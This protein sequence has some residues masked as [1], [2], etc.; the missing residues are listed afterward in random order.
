MT[1]GAPVS[2][3]C[4]RYPR[5]APTRPGADVSQPRAGRRWRQ[6]RDWLAGAGKGMKAT[7]A[8]LPA[9][10][11]KRSGTPHHPRACAILSRRGGW[12][13]MT[14]AT[15]ARGM[16]GGTT[17]RPGCWEMRAG[18]SCA[19]GGGRRAP[20]APL[21]SSAQ[22]PGE[23]ASGLRNG[24]GGGNL[25]S[26]QGLP[27]PC[28]LRGPG[29]GRGVWVTPSH[30]AGKPPPH[31]DVVFP[32]WRPAPPP[33]GQVSVACPPLRHDGRCMTPDGSTAAATHCSGKVPRAPLRGAQK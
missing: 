32:R 5:V 3:P 18:S 20:T 9:V 2:S 15:D 6:P 17:R 21:Q 8:R 1:V 19:D 12:V 29:M 30:Q 28:G 26:R 33:L 27:R 14:K 4:G 7:A 31:S 23:R 22:P 10:A 25:G 24:W 16:R 13:R 11:A